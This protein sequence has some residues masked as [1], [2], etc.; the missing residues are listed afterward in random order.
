[1]TVTHTMCKCSSFGSHVLALGASKSRKKY[2]AN[3][4]FFILLYALS[5]KIL[6]LQTIKTTKHKKTL[7]RIYI[8]P[9]VELDKTWG[10][11]GHME[12]TERTATVALVFSQRLWHFLFWKCQLCRRFLYINHNRNMYWWTRGTSCNHF[13]RKVAWSFIHT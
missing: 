11:F 1:M 6:K 3:W 5:V 9:V 10:E 7:L 2:R 8:I 13:D 4:F 12:Q